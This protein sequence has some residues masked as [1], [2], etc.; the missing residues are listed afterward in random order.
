MTKNVK[1]TKN[2]EKE[3]SKATKEYHIKTS[4]L[5]SVEI[6]KLECVGRYQKLVETQL[7]NLKKKVKGLGGRCRLTD[8]TIDQL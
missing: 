2:N 8:T 7:R 3:A 1:T 5:I 4:P 6:I